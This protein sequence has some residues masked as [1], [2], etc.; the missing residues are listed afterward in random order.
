MVSVYINGLLFLLVILLFIFVLRRRNIKFEYKETEKFTIINLSGDFNF[1]YT[2][3][4]Y[5]FFK[6]MSKENHLYIIKM[7]DVKSIDITALKELRHF[8]ERIKLKN[9]EV[10]LMG[11]NKQMHNIFTDPSET[12]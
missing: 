12:W 1:L 6:N 2:D 8:I 5:T 3:K 9:G 11:I 10:M 4:I 7:H